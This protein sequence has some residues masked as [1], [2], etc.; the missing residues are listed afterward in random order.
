MEQSHFALPQPNR[1]IP[2][3]LLQH[4]VGRP[5]QHSAEATA[6]QLISEPGLDVWNLRTSL[7]TGGSRGGAAYAGSVHIEIESA[8]LWESAR[9]AALAYLFTALVDDA[10]VAPLRSLRPSAVPASVLAWS[11]HLHRDRAHPMPHLHRD[12]EWSPSA[13]S[14]ADVLVCGPGP[15]PQA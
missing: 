14:T 10:L 8:V 12:R 11:P 9:G 1:W 15:P 3:K 4:G 6:S 5:S 13:A 7:L 2:Y